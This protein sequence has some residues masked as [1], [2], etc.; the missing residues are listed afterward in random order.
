MLSDLD[1]GHTVCRICAV[2]QFLVLLGTLR[3]DS[4]VQAYQSR[5]CSPWGAT[6][7]LSTVASYL[8]KMRMTREPVSLGKELGR[9]PQSQLVG[10][11][12]WRGLASSSGDQRFEVV[13]QEAQ[14][15]ERGGGLW[16]W[17]YLSILV[18]CDHLKFYPSSPVSP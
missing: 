12:L 10:L 16:L 7:S 4:A 1:V 18:L 6:N 8:V 2:L 17:G 14:G 13:A 11:E 5:P 15:G 3:A 9:R